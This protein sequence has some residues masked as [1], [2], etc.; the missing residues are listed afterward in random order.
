MSVSTVEASVSDTESLTVT[1][2]SAVAE[3]KDVSVADLSLYDVVDIDAVAE[4]FEP[5]ATTARTSGTVSFRF[6][7]RSVDVHADGTVVVSPP[8]A[9]QDSAAVSAD[10]D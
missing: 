8:N 4:L 1:V 10:A 6:A 5:T 2:V 3:S 7:D 9:T